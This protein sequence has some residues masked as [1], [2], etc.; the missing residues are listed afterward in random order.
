[1]RQAHFLADQHGQF[2]HMLLVARGVGVALLQTEAMAAS[3]FSRAFS[4]T[5]PGC[6]LLQDCW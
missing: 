3:A 6:L 5:G 2:G 4:S 1:V